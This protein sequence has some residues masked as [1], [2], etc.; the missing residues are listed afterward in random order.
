MSK[1][2][3][4]RYK[5]PF[6]LSV[7]MLFTLSLYFNATRL[8]TLNYFILIHSGEGDTCTFENFALINEEESVMFGSEPSIDLEN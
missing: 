5:Y 4:K 6:L 3:L 1:S 7:I 8:Q 2:K